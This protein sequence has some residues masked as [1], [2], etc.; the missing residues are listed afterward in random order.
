MPHV[1]ALQARFARLVAVRP[2]AVGQGS[3]GNVLKRP[4]A[5]GR[6]SRQCNAPPRRGTCDTRRR[7]PHPAAPLPPA[8]QHAEPIH[9]RRGL[10]KGEREPQVSQATQTKHPNSERPSS[11]SSRTPEAMPVAQ[12]LS[13]SVQATE[14]VPHAFVPFSRQSRAT[15]MGREESALEEIHTAGREKKECEAAQRQTER[16]LRGTALAS[17]NTGCLRCEKVTPW[18][19][20]PRSARR[21]FTDA[22]T[23]KEL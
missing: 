10:R 1:R 23:V 12:T 5:E 8:H 3:R 15:A 14:S 9:R 11:R 22:K 16:H 6:W 21:Q 2:A 18:R 17:R 13:S 7:L 4:Q 19:R 20:A